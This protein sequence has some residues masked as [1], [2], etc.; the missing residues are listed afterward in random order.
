[1]SW[2]QKKSLDRITS[3]WKARD[4][5]LTVSK[6]TREMNVENV[7]TKNGRLIQ[8]AH[9]YVTLAQSGQ[10]HC[11]DSDDHAR[12]AIQRL[13][14]WQSEVACMAKAFDLPIIAFQ[15]ARAHFLI[16]RPIDDDAA[17]ART[18]VLFARAISLMTA[19]AFNPL[20]GEADRF[21]AKS[22]VDLGQTVATRGGVR[23]DS[24]LLFLG[25]AANRPAK[26]LGGAKLLVTGRFAEAI[27]DDLKVELVDYAGDGDA[28]I[29][30]MVQAE[31]AAAVEKDG[32]DWSVEKSSTRLA[33]DL[34]K[35]PV[36]RFKV[37]GAKTR[38]EPTKLTRSD[39]KLVEAVA[40]IIDVDGF[41]AYVDA[42]EDDAVKRDAILTLDAIRQELRE[43]V[44][45]D[46]EAVRIQYQGDNLVVVL[47]LPAGDAA[48]IAEK[49]TEIAAAI[50]SSMSVTLPQVVPDA[51]KLDVAVGL[52]MNDTVVARLGE[53]AKRNALVLGPAA[54]K[55]EQIQMRLDGRQTGLDKNLYDNLSTVVQELYAWDESAKAYVATGLDASKQARIKEAQAANGHRT[56]T[57]GPA[58]RV[59]IGAPAA[60]PGTER[61]APVRPYAR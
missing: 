41:S 9:L 53:Y 60:I 24:E 55:A 36:E 51:S 25:N 48:K 43:V 5:N 20:F 16:Y 17:I 49:A 13:A 26:L 29:L 11:L 52:A 42:A 15:G 33:A 50:Q 40:L 30:K 44:K 8:G 38:I 3:R 28:K 37:S 46:F 1:M 54:T 4:T 6:L 45:V 39:S 22:A 31:V 47:H 56:V 34:A 18:A 59:L 35:W 12:S 19:K 2:N 58:G 23:A 27:A 10:I 7:T 32:I 57:P 21:D 61:V 14:I